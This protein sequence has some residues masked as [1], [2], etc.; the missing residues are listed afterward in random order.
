[1]KTY[2]LALNQIKHLAVVS[3]SVE[4]DGL[5]GAVHNGT[6]KPQTASGVPAGAT[7]WSS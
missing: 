1:M 4:K 5:R 2:G 6:V 3:G 7:Q